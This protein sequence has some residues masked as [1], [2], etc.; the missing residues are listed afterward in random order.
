MSMLVCEAPA[1]RPRQCR[2]EKVFS[3]VAREIIC[4]APYPERCEAVAVRKRTTRLREYGV[5]AG[6]M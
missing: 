6:N 1:E 5:R 4:A 2:Q 3:A